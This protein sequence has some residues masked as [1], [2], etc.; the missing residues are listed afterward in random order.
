MDNEVNELT[1][2]WRQTEASLPAGWT[3]DSLRCASEGLGPEQR[4][5]DWIAIAVGPS[6]EELRA[7]AADPIA[8]LLRLIPLV[9]KGALPAQ[10]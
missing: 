2:I 9:P 4:S 8:A 1:E 6:G 7:R 3:L 10:G 5:V